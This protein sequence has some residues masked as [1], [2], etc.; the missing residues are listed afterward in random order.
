MSMTQRANWLRRFLHR[1]T[2]LEPTLRFSLAYRPRDAWFD[3]EN[4]DH[5]SIDTLDPAGHFV[6][7][8]GGY[9][10]IH[11]A[12]IGR[13]LFD[14]HVGSGAAVATWQWDVRNQSGTSSGQTGTTSTTDHHALFVV[15]LPRYA[16][17]R[18]APSEATQDRVF[19]ECNANRFR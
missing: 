19:Y 4:V 5:L 13:Y 10:Q 2:S 15:D 11:I 3:A 9:V 18:L 8:P 7:R 16:S 17:L 6:L 1:D 12:E 14:C